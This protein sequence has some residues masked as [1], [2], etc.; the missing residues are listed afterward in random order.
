MGITTGFFGRVM[1]VVGRPEQSGCPGAVPFA[2]FVEE[3]IWRGYFIEKLIASGRTEREAIIYSA[4][5]FAFTHGIMIWDKLIVT[6]I[7]GLIA[8]LYYVR[9]RNIPE[10]MITHI[11]IDIIAFWLSL[12]SPI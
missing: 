3:I 12:F 9:E 11:V 7:W 8:G 2:G 5:S 1:V 6:F 4:A 10:L